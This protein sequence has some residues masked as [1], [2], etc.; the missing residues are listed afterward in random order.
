MPSRHLEQRAAARLTLLL[1]LGLPSAGAGAATPSLAGDWQIGAVVATISQT[2]DR[3]RAVWK[4]PA[5]GCKAGATWWEG[6]IEDAQIHGQ[7]YPCTGG[8]LEEP[9]TID[10]VDGGAALNVQI[11]AIGGSTLLTPIK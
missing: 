6:R 5:E 9:L 8:A 11:P 3:V 1:C 2:G 4:T 7:R 10:I